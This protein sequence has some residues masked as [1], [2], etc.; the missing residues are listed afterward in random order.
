MCKCECKARV[1]CKGQLK[2][3]DQHWLLNPAKMPVNLR[4][5][6]DHDYVH[7]LSESEATWLQEF[8]DAYYTGK[9]NDVS[10]TWSH[11]DLIE[12]YDR[13]RARRRDVYNQFHRCTTV[14]VFATKH[15]AKAKSQKTKE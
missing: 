12:S 6:I 3:D 8:D 4:Q 2:K 1:N 9:K 7:T 13:N 5:F 15:L 11:M 14:D 10:K